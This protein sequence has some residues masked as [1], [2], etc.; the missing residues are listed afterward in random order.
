MTAMARKDRETLPVAEAKRRFAEI[1]DRV[2]GEGRRY[3]I[4]RRGKPVMALVPVS[5]VERLLERRPPLGLAAGA[6][7]F[8]D[9]PEV[10]DA[11]DDAVRSRRR[12]KDRPVPPIF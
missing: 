5:D 3:V 12:A 6:G 11:I 8:A 4:T 9:A 1:A 2:A 10:L 7:L